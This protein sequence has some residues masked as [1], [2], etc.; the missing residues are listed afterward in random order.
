MRCDVILLVFL[1]LRRSP[2]KQRATSEALYAERV[3]EGDLGEPS[4]EP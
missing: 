3:R 2:F 1:F 4:L